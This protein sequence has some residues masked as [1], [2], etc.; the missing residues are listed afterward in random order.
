MLHKLKGREF[1]LLLDPASFANPLSVADANAFWTNNLEEV[2]LQTVG[3]SGII[4][5]FD[6]AR[7]RRIHFWDTQD[8]LLTRSALN[9]R[10]RQQSGKPDELTLKLQPKGNDMGAVG[11]TPMAGDAEFE[12]D[13]GPNGSRFA[14]SVE[15][16]FPWDAEAHTIDQLQSVFPSIKTIAA[17]ASDSSYAMPLQSGPTV[18]ERVLDG[19]TIL[20]EN[21][22]EAGFDLTMWN[23]ICAPEKR[24]AEI[25]FSHKL[26]KATPTGVA[27][28]NQLFDAIQAQ[29]A[30]MV[31]TQYSSKT[32]L[33]LPD[34]CGTI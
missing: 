6:R 20:L 28:G 24:I 29:L 21:D 30:G 34:S 22:V 4:K 31:N 23:F 33:A 17:S 25:S 1:K 18:E 5:G 16:D 26:K 19:A 12:E 7:D 13:I 8:C 11:N 10:L 15:I 27:L 3:N 9:L 14:L 2:I 32:A